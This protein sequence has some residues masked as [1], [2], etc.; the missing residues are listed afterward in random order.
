MTDIETKAA[1]GGLSAGPD[2]DCAPVKA[3]GKK[4]DLQA[5]VRFMKTLTIC[6]LIA[7]CILYTAMILVLES[8]LSLVPL[9]FA[10]MC[11]MNPSVAS[12]ILMSMLKY[13][14]LAA[15]FLDY[16]GMRETGD[17]LFISLSVATAGLFLVQASVYKYYSLLLYSETVGDKAR[18][19]T[20][21]VTST[22]TAIEVAP[23][24]SVV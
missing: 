17:L 10:L 14:G 19:A 11:L 7:D 9:F 18:V 8:W 12:F 23:T 6:F 4:A 13:V 24:D 3:R 16:N 2:A 5:A 15:L 22:A 1:L 21:E 20:L